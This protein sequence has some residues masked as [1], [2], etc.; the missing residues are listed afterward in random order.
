MAECLAQAVEIMAAG[1]PTNWVAGA[2][3]VGISLLL[4]LFGVSLL[5][6]LN[7]T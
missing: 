6:P 5:V 7:W 3:I 4:A 2:V 1:K